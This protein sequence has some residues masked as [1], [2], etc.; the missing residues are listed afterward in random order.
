MFLLNLYISI[1][2][3]VSTV[4]CPVEDLDIRISSLWWHHSTIVENVRQIRLF[5]Q[6]KA[7]VK[8]AKINLSSFVTSKYEKM[9]IWLFRQ[10][11]P[12]QTQ[13]CP[14][15]R[16]YPPQADL[17]HCLKCY[18][19]QGGKSNFPATTFG[20]PGMLCGIVHRKPRS[21]R[22]KKLTTS[23]MVANLRFEELNSGFVVSKFE[24]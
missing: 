9:D 19:S 5:M 12:K 24:Q 23:R 14:P 22:I 6:N 16:I 3:F 17:P 7:K 11:K 18:A 20:I 13:S 1:F 10:T 21:M 15:R 2:E 4:R 8:S